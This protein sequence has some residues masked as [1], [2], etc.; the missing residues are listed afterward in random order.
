MLMFGW[1]RLASRSGPAAGCMAGSGPLPN[2]RNAGAVV[3]Y[4]ADHE[5]H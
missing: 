4:L 5:T 2:C 1:Y 3:S